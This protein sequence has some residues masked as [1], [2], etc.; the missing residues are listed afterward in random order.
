MENHDEQAE[1]RARGGLS[2]GLMLAFLF[3]AIAVAAGLA[4]LIVN[5]FFH[6]HPR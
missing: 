6:Q 5:P 4:Y 1:H 2:F 3:V